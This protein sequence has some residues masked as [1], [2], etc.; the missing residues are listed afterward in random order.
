MYWRAVTTATNK[1]AKNT[2]ISVSRWVE[3]KSN[4]PVCT[5]PNITLIS[6]GLDVH[7]QVALRPP[8]GSSGLAYVL[9]KNGDRTT[10]TVTISGRPININADS[11]V[12]AW[13]DIPAKLPA[14]PTMDPIPGPTFESDVTTA[15]AEVAK[16]HPVALSPSVP[17]AQNGPFAQ[18]W[19]GSED[20][21]YDLT[22]S[23]ARHRGEFP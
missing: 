18:R 7:A 2:A 6:N 8:F 12:R 16:S 13:S 5:R 1:P 19:L 9:Q 14:G 11:S 23:S 22:P 17:I 4:P 3:I 20:G 10:R 21:A 15:E